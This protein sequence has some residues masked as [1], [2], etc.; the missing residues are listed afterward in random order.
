M[1]HVIYS[2]ANRIGEILINRPEK[3]NALSPTLVS[4]LKTAF[5]AAYDDPN[6]KVIILRASGKAFCAGADLQ[7]I[8]DLQSYS[9]EENYA[10]S[11]SLK[12]L[13][14]LMHRGPKVIVGQIE[15]AALA[16]GCGLA[17][18]CDISV[19]TPA[20]TFGYTEVK[21]GFIPAMVMVF[22]LRKMGEGNARLLLLTGQIVA[23]EEA[24]SLGLINEV[25][26]EDQIHARVQN[27]AEQLVLQASSNSL[28]L[29]KSMIPMV[30]QLSLEEA[31]DF[32]AAEN[33]KARSSE[34]CRHGIS[35]F[36][37]KTPISW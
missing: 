17:A 35:S 36:L 33:V 4:D 9:Y 8:M 2:C 6:C 10:D 25:A 29:I 34:D 24:C 11:Q 28:S 31:L 18:L 16:G 15:G 7:Y 1:E 12:E 20:A 13:F 5:R 26:A 27:I 23:A 3:R 14:L 19:A 37:N 32:A 30:Q 22:L 21:I